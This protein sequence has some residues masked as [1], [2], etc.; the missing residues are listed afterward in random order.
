M[1]PCTKKNIKV[2]VEVYDGQWQ[3]TA[4]SSEHGKTLNLLCLQNL[5]WN[6][7]SKMST[8]HILEDIMVL[9]QSYKWR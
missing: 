7:I 6:P 5:T 4:M 9:L 1:T 3:A 8:G 2:L